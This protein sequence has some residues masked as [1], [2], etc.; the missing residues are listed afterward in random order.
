MRTYLCVSYIKFVVVNYVDN[1]DDAVARLII[2]ATRIILFKL[3][4]L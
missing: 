4:G 2:W 3:Y 1:A